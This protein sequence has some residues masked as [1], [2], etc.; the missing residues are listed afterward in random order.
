MTSRLRIDL[1]HKPERLRFS[2]TPPLNYLTVMHSYLYFCA[3]N[4]QAWN[5]HIILD[6]SKL[7]LPKLAK[8]ELYT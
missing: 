7:E 5:R 4:A 1:N 8:Y 6:E 2:G 3:E